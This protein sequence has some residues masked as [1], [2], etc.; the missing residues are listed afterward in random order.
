M[1]VSS[2]CNLSDRQLINLSKALEHNSS[3]RRFGGVAEQSRT[4]KWECDAT[5]TVFFLFNFFRFGTGPR[6]NLDLHRYVLIIMSIVRLQCLRRQVLT[7]R[8]FIL[9]ELIFLGKKNTPKKSQWWWNT[10]N[11]NEHTRKKKNTIIIT[12]IKHVAASCGPC[13]NCCSLCC[14]SSIPRQSP[15]NIKQNK[16]RVSPAFD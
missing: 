13:F 8:S 7:Q 2:S 3:L 4:A 15:I 11:Q 12:F 1:W 10:S 14:I 5:M 16:N 9:I 6:L